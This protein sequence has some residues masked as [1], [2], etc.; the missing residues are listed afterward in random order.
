[1]TALGDLKGARVTL[2]GVAYKGGVSDIRET[3]TFVIAEGLSERDVGELRLTDPYVDSEHIDY[4]LSSLEESLDKIDAVVLVTDHPKYSAL[5]PKMFVKQ[6]RGNV[7]VD[8][9]AMLDRDRWEAA[10]FDVY[11]I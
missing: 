11:Q 5:S 2:L 1:L 6:M 9:R 8:T 7:I 4:E 10:D 3:P